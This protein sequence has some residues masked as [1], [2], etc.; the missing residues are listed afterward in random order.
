[1]YICISIYK[2]VIKNTGVA[3]GK[4]GSKKGAIGKRKAG[5]SVVITSS[6][7]LSSSIDWTHLDS[8]IGYV[9]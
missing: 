4:G 2:Y 5:S 8:G 9:Y 3:K 6:V 1:M 7:P